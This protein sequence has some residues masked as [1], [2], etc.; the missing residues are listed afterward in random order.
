MSEMRISDH[1]VKEDQV[2]TKDRGLSEATVFFALRE[3]Y[4][5]RYSDAFGNSKYVSG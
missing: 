2:K 1:D 4:L 3:F 5:R